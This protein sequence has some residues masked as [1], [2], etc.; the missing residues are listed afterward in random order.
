MDD[1]ECDLQ[2]SELLL[3][4]PLLVQSTWTDLQTEPKIKNTRRVGGKGERSSQLSEGVLSDLAALVCWSI[5]VW[6]VFMRTQQSS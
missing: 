3:T 1:V 6:M 2:E 4:T 5:E